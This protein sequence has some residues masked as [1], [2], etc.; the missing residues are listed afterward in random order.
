MHE[1][2][3]EQTREAIERS[4]FRLIN[5]ERIEFEGGNE[6]TSI[7]VIHDSI[8]KPLGKGFYI[9]QLDRDGYRFQAIDGGG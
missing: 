3:A 1:T 2:R 4:G 9:K 6:P 7:D 5:R 8:I